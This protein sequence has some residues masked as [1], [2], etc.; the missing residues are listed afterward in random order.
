MH[1]EVEPVAKLDRRFGEA[2]PALDV[3]ARRGRQR[4]VDEDADPQLP[5][6]QIRAGIPHCFGRGAKHACR[7]HLCR[8]P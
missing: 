2:L 7:H 6:V 8:V 3:A 5:L 4:Q 1:R